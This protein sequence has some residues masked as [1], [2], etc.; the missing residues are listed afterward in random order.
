MNK[1]NQPL[2][3]FFDG[4]FRLAIETQTPIVPFAILNSKEHLPRKNPLLLNPGII[5]MK[6]GAV[7]PVAGL[8]AS[9]LEKLKASTFNTILSMLESHST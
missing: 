2:A 7:I 1:S 9:D 4:A 3:P 8:Q 5:D 6:F